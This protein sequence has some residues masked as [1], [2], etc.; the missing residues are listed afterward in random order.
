M[1]TYSDLIRWRLP[2]LASAKSRC[3]QRR[4]LPRSHR[5]RWS[6]RSSSSRREVD[7]SC[8]G[9]SCNSCEAEGGCS[10]PSSSSSDDE[11]WGPPRLTHPHPNHTPLTPLYVCHSDTE[12]AMP[13][14]FENS[15][16]K[17]CF[18]L[19]SLQRSS[20]SLES[21]EH[22][23]LRERPYNS[24]KKKSR[25]DP[26]TETWQ[27]SPGA[28]AN[29]ENKD[30]FWAALKNNYQ[31]LMDN[32]LIESCREAGKELG[33]PDTDWSF[34]KLT[35]QFVELNSWLT[36]IQETVYSREE[37]VVDP[38]LKRTQFEELQRK[39]YRRKLFNNQGDRLVARFPELKNEVAW[40]IEHLNTKW[41]RLEQT[42]SP[43]TKMHSAHMDVCIDVEHELMCLKKWIKQTD[44]KLPSIDFHSKWTPAEL[45]EKSKEHEVVQR[46]VES[47]AKIVRR[48]VKLCER[49][50]SDC[51]DC[52][53]SD[54]SDAAVT[55]FVR[56]RRLE[57][58]Q[59]IKHARALERRW[60]HLY[61]R[62]LEWL[63]HIDQVASTLR[64]SSPQ[65]NELLNSPES[66]EEP[67]LKHARL[68]DQSLA[69]SNDPQCD[70]LVIDETMIS[71]DC[72]TADEIMVGPQVSMEY[73]H[74]SNPEIMS[75]VDMSLI[76]KSSN[77]QNDDTANE[78]PKTEQPS[79]L[80]RRQSVPLE[81]I[82]ARR[83]F[84]DETSRFNQSGRRGNN[85]AVLYFKHPDTDS[86]HEAAKEAA[87]LQGD[88]KVATEEGG[89][90]S[91]GGGNLMSSSEEDEW[92]YR[93][94]DEAE[95]NTCANLS[96]EGGASLTR[97][98]SQRSTATAH[99]N[100][101]LPRT[102]RRLVNKAEEL[103]REEVVCA[104]PARK[105]SRLFEPL[106]F[107]GSS[108][109]KNSKVK[110]WLRLQAQD[111]DDK[112]L[113]LAFDG[114]AF[115]CQAVGDSCDASSEYT[116]GDDDF[117]R[118]SSDEFNTSSNATAT[119]HQSSDALD[120]GS[121]SFYND[122]SS[123]A[124]IVP[125]S[126]EHTK[127][128]MR[129]KRREG[130]QVRPW[131]LSGIPQLLSSDAAQLSHSLS[132]SE[133]AL[134]Q[135]QSKMESTLSS[136]TVEEATAVS[137]Q[138]DGSGGG[139]SSN[140]LRRRKLK[141]RKRNAGRKSDSGS[142][143]VCQLE[144]GSALKSTSVLR[145]VVTNSGTETEEE[146]CEEALAGGGVGGGLGAG[147]VGGKGGARAV[148]RKLM[149]LPAFRLGPTLGVVTNFSSSTPGDKVVSA[150]SS[151][152]EQA[153]DSYQEKYMSEAYSEE[154]ADPE[155][156]RRLLDF[157]DDYRN[158]IDSQSD[159][160]SSFGRPLHRRGR[161]PAE[162]SSMIDSDSDEM[163]DINRMIHQ[164]STQFLAC[165]QFINRETS[166][167]SPQ[168]VIKTKFDEVL[169]IS[170]RNVD[171]LRKL[172]KFIEES[173]N[174]VSPQ[175]CREIRLLIERW[176]ALKS[177]TEDLQRMCSLQIEM[178]SYKDSLSEMNNRLNQLEKDID[179]QDELQQ[180][181]KL[182]KNELT[183]L[184]DM[185]EQLMQVKESV[186]NF[187]SD[188]GNASSAILK[189]EVADLLRQW[190]D[191]S[192]RV[193]QQLSTLQSL[194]DA[195]QL[196]EVHLSELQL[197][198]R[199]DHKTM[200]MLDTALNKGGTV[201]SDVATSVR[202]VAKVLSEKQDG[203]SEDGL[204]AS[205]D[206]SIVVLGSQTIEGGSCSGCG[207]V[208][209][210]GISD[211]GSDQE[212]SERE[213]RLAML[214]RLARQLEA[215]LSKHWPGSKAINDLKKQIC[216]I[217]TKLKDLQQTCRQ[218]IVRTAECAEAKV[219]RKSLPLD[220][221]NNTV[222][223][224]PRILSSRQCDK[225]ACSSDNLGLGDPDDPE[226]GKP[227]SWLWRVMRAALPFQMA[228]MAIFCIACLLEPNCC[229]NINNLNL[230]FSPQ[231]RYYNGSPP[232]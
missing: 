75:E 107:D 2:N 158:F 191:A 63:C 192:K 103:V 120:G 87:M 28:C 134:H 11:W 16:M 37:T 136:S 182:V 201:S 225:K 175:E 177:K 137:C 48:V 14:G 144:P 203:S 221:A 126:P 36:S 97:S 176:E 135:L 34:D 61:L 50:S 7:E 46:D 100:T 172:V 212:M 93:C 152:S 165:E 24:L 227:N 111:I 49:V 156:A 54:C 15:A 6:H 113:E 218:L 161:L 35:D 5:H 99:H 92:T 159:C 222:D 80:P 25:N 38:L 220:F 219:A 141:L 84:L 208:S 1:E 149:A 186:H 59:L 116:T 82:S 160:A 138:Q 142:D 52:S 224:A 183:S 167:P 85:C 86:E 213:K 55:S 101:T 129:L 148:R 226:P 168:F 229:D 21:P 47:H 110:E 39:S 73:R 170:V 200:L 108:K 185:K 145:R 42:V 81:N 181:I 197:A 124:T 193:K 146:C 206:S 104:S 3:S 109:S 198:L 8:S 123:P 210:S 118:H 230:S 41:E 214:R 196:F 150:D 66:D 22:A 20:N 231:L 157:G 178:A 90:A 98:D 71:M 114:S 171:C 70:D 74:H 19:S 72:Y 79:K 18:S 174:I 202:D 119:C 51:S 102:I 68:S 78:S 17:T 44:R 217:E 130:L 56:G 9:S 45:N 95:A 188:T 65:E 4:C 64:N 91:S 30:E 162:D 121:T 232:V 69:W 112:A 115:S 195:W 151:F 32:N 199:G 67:V 140:S 155:T 89:N 211:S 96:S 58:T 166:N 60:E 131:S 122:K 94:G 173:D 207:F 27:R 132:T 143:G 105:A 33:Y 13:G 139:Y 23:R 147:P 215:E 62:S 31:Y 179:D 180:R 205:T 83:Q 169:A 204:L 128:V 53:R 57:P 106:R 184:K 190:E 26:D 187:L 12:A 153:W 29:E 117:E 223:V 10:S 164:S 209:D 216:T 189:E 127:V 154:T 43:R 228:I 88:E 133:S 76:P 77:S 40:R 194:S 163:D 125:N